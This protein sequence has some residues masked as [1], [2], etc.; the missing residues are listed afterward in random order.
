VP[1]PGLR[2]WQVVAL[3]ALVLVFTVARNLPSGAF[4]AP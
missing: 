3:I 1:L 4:L 2:T